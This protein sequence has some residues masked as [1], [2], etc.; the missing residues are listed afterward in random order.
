MTPPPFFIVGCDRSGTTMLRLILD[1]SPDVAIPTE[2]MIVVDFAGQAGDPLATDE[3]FDEARRRRLAPSEGTPVG[4]SRRA[5]ASAGAHRPGCL[6]GGAR[7]AVPGLRRA[8][9]EAALGR[10]DPVLRRR[11]R[12]G[13]A[14]VPGGPDREPRPGRP[15]RGALAP[16]RAVRP[17][18]RL[19]R[20]APVAGGRRRGRHRLG[21]LW[22]RRAHD[23]LRGSRFR[24]RARRAAGVRVLRD[25]LPAADARDRGC[26]GGQAGRRPGGVVHRA[27]RGDRHPLGGEVAHGDDALTAGGLRR[28][29]VGGA[30]PARLRRARR[31]RASAPSRRWPT[32]PTTGRSRSG[33]SPAST[34]GRSGAARCRT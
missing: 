5:T 15:R 24:P 7:G 28:R 3:E 32:P 14:R 1:G 34:C 10:Q 2:S 4:P 29:R 33:T 21:P 13:E 17:R 27:L 22:R 8:A 11:A 9:W 31:R 30:S 20:R 25:R 16:A 18:E 23:P 6:P 12:P 19:G 26:G